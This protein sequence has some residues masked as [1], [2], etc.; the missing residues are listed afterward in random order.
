MKRFLTAA[1]EQILQEERRQLTSLRVCLARL[2][3]GPDDVDVLDRALRQIEEL[4][5]L[6]VVGEFNSGKSAFINALL[7]KRFLSEGVTPT[8]TQ[9]HILRYGEQIAEHQPEPDVAVI[10]YPVD[11]LQEINVVDTPGTNAIIL[12]HQEITEDFVPRADLILF[13]TSSDRP[14]SESERLFME[15]IREWGKKVVVVLNKVDILETPGDVDHVVEF[16]ESNA[17]A[18]LG[19]RPMVFPVSSRLARQA[20]ETFDGDA[21]NR[22]WAASQFGPLERYILHTLDE[23]ERLRLKL[24]SPLGIAYRLTE[25][26]L[27]LARRR[28]ALL[29]GDVD[30]IATIESQLAAFEADMR[31]EFK[32]H[33]GLI[34]NVLY[35]MSERGDRFFDDTIRLGRI[36]DL[37]NADRVRG[38]FE[39]EVVADTTS[40]VETQTHDLIDWIVAQ[41]YKQWQDV[42]EFLNRRIAQH[43]ERIVGSVGGQFEYNR[44]ALLQSVGRAARDAVATYDKEAEARELADSVQMA[45]AQTALVE[46]GAIGLGALM[47]KLLATT[48]ADVSGILAASA[49]AALG[50]YLIPNKRRRAKNDLHAKITDLRLRLTQAITAQFER[51]LGGSLNRIRGAMRPYTRFVETQRSSLQGTLTTLEDTEQAL[52]ALNSQ[53]E[54]LSLAA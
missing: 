34:D 31:R 22:L 4:F 6:V 16:V 27:E 54:A 18:L 39:R 21:R 3:A 49:V 43:E 40:D 13:V 51:E 12:R 15:R 46:V 30:T 8:T 38:M 23:R 37:V 36:L 17:R 32:Y 42:M 9:V 50:L 24:G 11:W 2:D 48:L 44:Q 45:V 20:K 26:Y 52:S 10:N 33:I 29:R 28:Q 14:F 41:N 7:G 19:H 47:V 53:V 25:R 1:E 35:A 5:L